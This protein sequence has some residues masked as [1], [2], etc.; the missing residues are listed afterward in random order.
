MPQ[1]YRLV[2]LVP[3]AFI[4]SLIIAYSMGLQLDQA[5]KWGI[6]FTGMFALVFIFFAYPKGREDW[7]F[8]LGETLSMLGIVI[9]ALAVVALAFYI[10][11][12]WADPDWRGIAVFMAYTITIV[13]GILGVFISLHGSPGLLGGGE[14]GGDWWSGGGG[15]GQKESKWGV[16]DVEQRYGKRLGW[17]GSGT[18]P[19]K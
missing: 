7:N 14:G 10:C 12:K 2:F 8:S 16:P 18:Q 13:F 1:D 3:I 4:I 6:I 17:A 5:I 11:V 9:I 19:K 15:G